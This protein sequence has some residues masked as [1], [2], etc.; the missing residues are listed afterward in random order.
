MSD[1]G[2]NILGLCSA[3]YLKIHCMNR[4]NSLLITNLLV[5]MVVIRNSVD[6]DQLATSNAS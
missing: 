2:E 3:I 5:L 4:T 1:F 6:P